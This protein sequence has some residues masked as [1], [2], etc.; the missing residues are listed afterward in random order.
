MGGMLLSVEVWIIVEGSGAHEEEHQREKLTGQSL[1]RSYR[2]YPKGIS[3]HVSTEV[4]L[5]SV[6]F[7]LFSS[8]TFDLTSVLC[9]LRQLMRVMTSKGSNS[10]AAVMP[11]HRD[12]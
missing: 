7:N 9:T 8:Q 2:L 12:T 10:L 4:Q 6:H 3:F 11:V 1:P 5:V